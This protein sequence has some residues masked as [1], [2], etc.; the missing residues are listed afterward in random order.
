[1]SDAYDPMAEMGEGEDEPWWNLEQRQASWTLQGVTLVEGVLRWQFEMRRH[2]DDRP[3]SVTVEHDLGAVGSSLAE[4]W[5][6]YEAELVEKGARKARTSG[7][8]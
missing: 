6:A 1:M 4:A 5:L 7:E 3:R 2:H 8:G